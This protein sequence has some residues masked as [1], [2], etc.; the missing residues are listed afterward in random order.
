MSPDSSMNSTK[1]LSPVIM[2]NINSQPTTTT[3][4][5]HHQSVIRLRC[6]TPPTYNYQVQEVGEIK[7]IYQ[8][9]S[10]GYRSVAP[11]STQHHQQVN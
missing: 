5:M 11:P 2:A 4:T 6:K 10:Q 8:T 9:S 7:S 1:M 3:S